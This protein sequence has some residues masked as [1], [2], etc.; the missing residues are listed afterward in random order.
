MHSG[1]DI[2]TQL[3][4]LWNNKV[5]VVQSQGQKFMRAWG[6]NDNRMN[7]MPH[8]FKFKWQKIATV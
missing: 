1:L 4:S 6:K 5:L 2:A 7:K 3:F 8:K